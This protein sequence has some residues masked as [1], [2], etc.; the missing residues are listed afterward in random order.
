M[1][2][3]KSKRVM[4]I[5]MF[6]VTLTLMAMLS[7]EAFGGDCAK[8]ID[9]LNVKDLSWKVDIG[10]SDYHWVFYKIIIQS[11][12]TSPVWV[13]IE[14]KFYVTEGTG[15]DTVTKVLVSDELLNE[16]V[17]EGENLLSGYFRCSYVTALGLLH[18]PTKM[19]IWYSARY[20]LF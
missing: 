13:D 18:Y 12:C 15:K 2:K 14:A 6:A 8:A 7:R 4:S 3:M 16:R 5:T 10:E 20:K 11:K 1:I 19:K 9:C 17:L